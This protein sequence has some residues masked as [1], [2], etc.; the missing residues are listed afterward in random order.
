MSYSNFI[1]IIISCFFNFLEYTKKIFELIINN[2]FIKTII[3]I[4]LIYLVIEYF[5]E[6][7]SFIRNI[8]SMKKEASKNKVASNTDI[9]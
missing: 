2:N 6:I 7:L 9:E 4:T 5:G 8:F 1:D 3:F